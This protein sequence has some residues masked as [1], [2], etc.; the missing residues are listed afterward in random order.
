MQTAI[1][2][3][4]AISGIINMSPL[5]WCIA[6]GSGVMGGK[7]L[8]ILPMVSSTADLWPQDC[9]HGINASL[10]SGEDTQGW[11][12]WRLPSMLASREQIRMS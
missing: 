1:E 9:E 12:V 6:C 7:R 4:E 8:L 2:H 11:M 5:P 3:V 10:M